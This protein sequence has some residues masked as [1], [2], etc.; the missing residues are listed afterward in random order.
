MALSFEDVFRDLK[1]SGRIKDDDSSSDEETATILTTTEI[2][3]IR[4]GNS[5]SEDNSNKTT[6]L[7]TKKIATDCNK[8]LFTKK[9]LRPV[10]TAYDI[11]DGLTFCGLRITLVQ[12]MGKKKKKELYVDTS[13]RPDDS[14]SETSDEASDVDTSYRPDDSISETS[15]EMTG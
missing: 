14:I 3:T 10:K 5:Y 1:K 4:S 7:P 6:F 2:G 9:T 8:T 13:Y 11:L 12:T 15:D